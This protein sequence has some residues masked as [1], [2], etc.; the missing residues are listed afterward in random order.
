MGE[1]WI[2]VLP[3]NHHDSETLNRDYEGTR[4]PS[5]SKNFSAAVA[6]TTDAAIEVEIGKTL[7]ALGRTEALGL[8]TG[9]SNSVSRSRRGLLFER[10]GGG[11][12][13]GH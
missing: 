5:D 11:P 6:N 4:S 2:Q 10:D 12:G 9:R 13:G 7:T 1:L 3:G 8:S